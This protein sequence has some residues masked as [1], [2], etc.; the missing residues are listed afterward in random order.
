MMKQKHQIHKTFKWIVLAMSILFIVSKTNAF[1]PLSLHTKDAYVVH[2][3]ISFAQKSTPMK[4]RQGLKATSMKENDEGRQRANGI[5]VLLTVPLAW[6]TYNPVVKYLYTIDPPVPGLVFSAAYYIVAAFTLWSIVALSKKDSSTSN[7]VWAGG[8]ELGGYLFLGNLVQVVALRTVPADRAGFLV[9][10]TTIIVPFL[11]AFLNQTVLP[12]R[13]WA[14]CWIALAGVVC[15]EFDAAIEGMTSGDALMLCAAVFYSLHVVRL[16][17]YAA[18]TEPLELAACKATFESVLSVALVGLLW[19]GNFSIEAA[20]DIQR[21][22][23]SAVDGSLR[24]EAWRPALGAVLWTG[25]VTCAYTIYAQSYG[26]R[27]VKPTD[28]NLIYTVQPIFT[29]LFALLLLNETIG[30]NGILGGSLILCS[31]YMIGS[32]PTNKSDASVVLEDN[33]Q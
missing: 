25:W 13:T 6:G 8:I 10:L 33:Q 29:A 23:A 19:Q 32:S 9:Q 17:S 27:R 12:S 7:P 4:Q 15:L 21:F 5:V 26:Q 18:K 24:I 28:A 1:V 22:L 2:K 11:D 30:T 16:G 3:S 20:T 31:V 14:A